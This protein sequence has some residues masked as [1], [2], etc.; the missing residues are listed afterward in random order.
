M[1]WDGFLEGGEDEDESARTDRQG[2]AR[3]TK[4]RYIYIY[5]YVEYGTHAPA[6]EPI[7]SASFDILSLGGFSFFSFNVAVASS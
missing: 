4:R 5:I 2:E 7:F 3:E 6:R 1:G